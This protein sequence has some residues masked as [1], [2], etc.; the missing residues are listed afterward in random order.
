[1]RIMTIVTTMVLCLLLI[2]SAT[3]LAL[4]INIGDGDIRIRT[5]IEAP[6]PVEFAQPPEL[7]PIPGRYVYFV[8]DIDLDLFFY[9]RHWFRPYKKHWFRSDNYAGTVGT[10]APSSVSFD[11]PTARLQN[12]STWILSH[13]VRRTEK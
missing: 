12:H 10:R 3:V 2:F 8:P 1:M 5:G 7:V 4:D 9:Q 6:P 13:P 11:R